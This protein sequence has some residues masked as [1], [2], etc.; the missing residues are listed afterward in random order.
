MDDNKNNAGCAAGCLGGCLLSSLLIAFVLIFICLAPVMGAFS[1]LSIGGGES[2]TTNS[3]NEIVETTELLH[4]FGSPFPG[5]FRFTAPDYPYDGTNHTGEDLGPLGND[6]RIL[7]MYDATVIDVRTGCNPHEQCPSGATNPKL[8][9]WGGNQ[10]VLEFKHKKWPKKKV[11]L[12]Y[13]HMSVVTV[14][15]GD[16]VSKG[17]V[18]GAMGETGNAYGPHLHLIL[19]KGKDWASAESMGPKKILGKGDKTNKKAR[20]TNPEIVLISTRKGELYE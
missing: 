14:K 3:S 9:D 7:A 20:L 1:F 17:Q 18:I 12:N 4:G 2:G 10:V 11:F 15:V 13:C 6:I 5:G 8:Q 16:T 19:A